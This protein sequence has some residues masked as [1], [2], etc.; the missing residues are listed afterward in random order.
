MNSIRKRDILYRRLTKTKSSSL[1]YEKKENDLKTH[2]VLLK[3]LLRKTKKDYYTNEFTKFANDCKNTWKLINE[4]AGRKAKKSELPSYFKKKSKVSKTQ[5]KIEEIHDEQSIADEFNKY[6][7]NV[8]ADL[9]A[10]IKYDGKNTVNYY[11]TAN[12][13]SKFNFELVNDEQVLEIIGSLEPKT[14]SGYDKISTKLLIQ[15]S[16]TIH[17]IL[18]IILNQSLIT[19]IFPQKLKQ[20]W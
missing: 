17:S 7:V 20:Q 15:L 13:T 1:S 5:T 3:K 10:A 11:L 12:I 14:S 19:G 6:F 8:G 9:S 18:R 2:S 4:I 16:P